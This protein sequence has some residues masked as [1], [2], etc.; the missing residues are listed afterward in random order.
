MRRARFARAVVK[1]ISERRPRRRRSAKLSGSTSAAPETQRRRARSRLARRDARPCRRSLLGATHLLITAPVPSLFCN[2]GR[3]RPVVDNP[4]IP[5]CLVLAARRRCRGRA[6]HLRDRFD[7]A[8]HTV[9]RGLVRLSRASAACCGPGSADAVAD[10]PY[11]VPLAAAPDRDDRRR[12]RDGARSSSI[13]SPPLAIVNALVAPSPAHAVCASSPL[14][15]VGIGFLSLVIGR[16]QRRRRAQ[17]SSPPAAS[18]STSR[19]Q[20]RKA[21]H[22]VDEFENSGRGWFWETNTQGTL[23]YVS[24]QLADDF[25]CEPEELLG[26]QFTDLLSVDTSSATA[27]AR[28]A[29][30]SASTCRRASPS[31]TWS[32]APR[33]TRTFTGRC[34]AIRSSTSAAASSAS[35]ASAPT[36]P[37]SAAPS[38]KSA[39]LARFNSLTGLPNRALMRQTLDEALRNAA[40]PAEGLRAVPDRSRPLQERQRHARPPDRR[41]AAAPGRRAP[42]VGDGRPRP[43]RPPGRRR[44]QGGASRHG[45]HRPARI[46]CADADRAGFAALHDRGPQGD[47]RRVGRH[48]HRRSRAAPAP[49]A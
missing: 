23:S 40:Q 18:A 35:A 39:R 19:P 10:D 5:S 45:R 11:I 28:S 22:F 14:I 15:G 6:L 49:T 29:R 21:L 44:V 32:S 12:H 20:A 31:P 4:L 17:R 8:P 24:Q 16:L 33:A 25:K 27:C 34:R 7:L 2:A 26:R 38:R 46:A 13:N 30:R 1:P 43:G 42:E 3:R 36:S 48:R 47:D 37:S 9:V 41:R